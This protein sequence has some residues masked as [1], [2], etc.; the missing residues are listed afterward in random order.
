MVQCNYGTYIEVHPA[1]DFITDEL[2]RLLE[3]ER[4]RIREERT[5]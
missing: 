3:A 5:R 1:Y 4:I 2:F